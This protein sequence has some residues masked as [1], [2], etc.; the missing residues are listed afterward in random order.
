MDEFIAIEEDSGAWRDYDSP[1]ITKVNLPN[2]L[3]HKE[4]YLNKKYKEADVVISVP[5]LK[6]YWHAA[7][8]GGIKN[9]GIGATPANI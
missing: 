9:V 7:I 3:L 4:Y 5:C 6:N 2:G 8:T 1:G